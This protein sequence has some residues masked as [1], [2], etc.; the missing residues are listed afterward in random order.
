[1]P[2]ADSVTPIRL[3]FCLLL[4]GYDNPNRRSDSYARVY[5]G[6]PDEFFLGEACYASCR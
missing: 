3:G 2:I 6:R 4:H 1:M 5:S